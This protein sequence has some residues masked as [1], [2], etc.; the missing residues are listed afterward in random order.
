[1]APLSHDLD[2]EQ[3]VCISVI[4]GTLNVFPDPV[5]I[6]IKEKHR[7]HWFLA[8]DGVIDSI[9]FASANGPFRGGHNIPKSKKHVLFRLRDV[10]P[11]AEGPVG[12]R[13]LDRVD[14]S[15]T[16]EE[17]VRAMFFFDRDGHGIRK[18]VQGASYYANANWLF[19]VQVV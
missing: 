3:P 12:R 8:G 9:K 14:D 19:V 2:D 4:G 18:N 10:V 6:S 15:V 5:P 16:G 13:E 11:P 7:A 17:P 1:M